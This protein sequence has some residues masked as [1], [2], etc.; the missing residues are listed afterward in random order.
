[1]GN[2]IVSQTESRTVS[3]DRGQL[4]AP[5]LV[6]S[7]ANGDLMEFKQPIT[8]GEIVKPN[9]TFITSSES[10]E[11]GWHLQ[12]LSNDEVL[13]NGQLYFLLPVCFSIC[14]LSIHDLCDLAVKVSDALAINH[15]SQRSAK[16]SVE[17]QSCYPIPDVN[18][19]VDKVEKLKFR[20]STSRK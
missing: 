19:L 10:M 17:V 2:K 7:V 8:A 16:G 3:T 14:P 5:A 1:M 18:H 20:R 15:R 6:F 13:Q 12:H 11:V 9:A 4:N